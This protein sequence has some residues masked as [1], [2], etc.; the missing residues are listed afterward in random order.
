MGVMKDQWVELGAV[1]SDGRESGE[2]EG[3]ERGGRGLFVCI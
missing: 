1:P 2:N 3:G